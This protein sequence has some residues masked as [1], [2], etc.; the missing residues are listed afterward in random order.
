MQIQADLKRFAILYVDDEEK[1]LKYFSK[2]YGD[3]F[4]V[5][6]ACNAAEGLKLLEEQGD[7]IAVI[8]SDQRMPGEKGVQLLERARQMC[9]LMVRMLI[10]AYA[11]FAVTVDAVNIGSVFRYISKPIQIEDV[12]NSLQRGIEFFILQ[13]ERNDLLQEKLSMLQNLLITDRVMSLAVAASSINRDL[14]N[15]L[16]ALQAFLDLKIGRMNRQQTSLESLSDPVFWR[17]FHDLVASQAGKIAMLLGDVAAGSS[18]G[19]AT[20]LGLVL[21]TV[22]KEQS[23]VYAGRGI[24]LDFTIEGSLPPSHAS[25]SVVKKMIQL[26]LQAESALLAAGGQITVKASSLKEGSLSIAVCTKGTSDLASSIHSILDPFSLQ[27]GGSDEAALN[28][29]GAYL[30][31]YHLGGQV[32]ATILA[33]QGF[34]FD[35][36]VLTQ[37]AP[38]SDTLAGSRD[39]IAKVLMNDNLWERLLP[40]A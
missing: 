12:R 14:R 21:K 28:M 8:L 36:T 20:D 38:P 30:L 24:V 19:V 37:E 27:S 10:T 3:E 39:F 1:A 9:P 15:P 16:Y 25:A 7:E 17:R 4:R 22:I 11:D 23:A 34:L 32:S 18:S 13:H 31:A 29:L 40:E 6:T 5:L 2:T 26:L 33:D 35:F